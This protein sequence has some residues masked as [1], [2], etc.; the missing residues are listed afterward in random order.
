MD[1]TVRLPS[2]F[3]LAHGPV[4]GERAL[5]G[6]APRS[7]PVRDGAVERIVGLAIEPVVIDLV[8]DRLVIDLDAEARLGW[9]FDVAVRELKG[10][11]QVSLSK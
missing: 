4:W 6:R 5:G 10:L 11:L 1:L 8:G 3:T 7:L 9:Q 2:Q